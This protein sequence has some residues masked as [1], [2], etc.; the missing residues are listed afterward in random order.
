VAQ[1][2]KISMRK[3]PNSSTGPDTP[4]FSELN[5]M[6]LQMILLAYF[7]GKPLGTCCYMEG[8]ISLDEAH[9]DMLCRLIGVQRQLEQFREELVAQISTANTTP[10]NFRKEFQLGAM[11]ALV[12]SILDELREEINQFITAEH[13]QT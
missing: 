3:H 9:D 1:T 5:P 6:N 11:T 13:D 12:M 8:G 2:Y 10:R 7:R 4:F